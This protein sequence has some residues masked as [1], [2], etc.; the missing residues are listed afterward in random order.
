MLASINILS[1]LILSYLILG[2]HYHACRVLK[3]ICFSGGFS[4]RRP[5]GR[6]ITRMGR[7]AERCLSF[8]NVIFCGFLLHL[9]IVFAPHLDF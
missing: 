2:L 9:L 8:H 5:G 4:H 1:Y 7:G 3:Y 6:T